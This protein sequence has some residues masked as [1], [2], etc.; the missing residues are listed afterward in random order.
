MWNNGLRSPTTGCGSIFGTTQWM[1]DALPEPCCRLPSCASLRQA[2]EPSH[3]RQTRLEL[4][5]GR[6]S[7][8]L[9]HIRPNL[10]RWY[11]S[12][13][14]WACAR[15]CS[16]PRLQYILL[17]RICTRQYPRKCFNFWRQSLYPQ[18]SYLGWRKSR[19]PK[20]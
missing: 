11:K 2:E 12:V 10:I 8:L 14:M 5:A 20:R 16:H 6:Y 17:T 1:H 19:G 13:R 4:R 18:I 3:Q 7:R 9:A 15:L